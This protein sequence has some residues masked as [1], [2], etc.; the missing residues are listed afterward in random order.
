[1]DPELR[2]AFWDFFRD[3]KAQGVT[4]LVTTHYMDEASRCDRVGFMRNGKLIAE[5]GP[6]DLLAASGCASLE[7]AFIKFARADS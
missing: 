2:W 7:D 4:L 3:L 1:M 6:A 5:G